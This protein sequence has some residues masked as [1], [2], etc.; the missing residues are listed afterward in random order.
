MVAFSEAS[1]FLFSS[2][3]DQRLHL[4]NKMMLF[5]PLAWIY[6]LRAFALSWRQTFPWCWRVCLQLL[7][8]ALW[9]RFCRHLLKK[10]APSKISLSIRD[11]TQQ[12]PS[13]HLQI[14][15]S[16]SSTDGSRP[17]TI[18][19]GHLRPHY[20]H[21]ECQRANRSQRQDAMSLSVAGVCREK[22]IELS[23]LLSSHEVLQK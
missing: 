8:A 10:C 4:P 16:H 21:G 22:R 15:S 19:T 20:H 17:Q 3:H 2:T 9:L 6:W 11:R 7:G 14:T 5:S 18:A 13:V 12:R 23:V 1:F